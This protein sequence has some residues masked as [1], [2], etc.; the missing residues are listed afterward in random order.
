MDTGDWI[1]LGQLVVLA[2]AALYARKQVAEARALREARSRP[3]VV[4]DIDPWSKKGVLLLTIENLGQTMARDVQLSL[5]PRLQSTLDGRANWPDIANFKIFRDGIP[6]L[7]PGKR[8]ACT[9]DTP[10]RFFKSNLPR[11]YTVSVTYEGPTGAYTETY[12]LDLDM[13]RELPTTIS[14]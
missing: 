9:L 1:A 7:P 2:V 14:D 4:V 11:L 13:Y 3:F 6:S 8:L 10:T 5:V 12:V